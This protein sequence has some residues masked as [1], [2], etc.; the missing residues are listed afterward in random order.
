[1]AREN[2]KSQVLVVDDDRVL[3]ASF[4]KY[5]PRLNHNLAVGICDSSLQALT[6]VM[7]KDYDAIVVDIKMPEM[8]G[9]A[10]LRE[11]RKIRPDTPVFL[12]TGYY[13]SYDQAI[14]ALRGGATDFIHKP[15][16]WEHFISSLELAIQDYQ[17]KRQ[18]NRERVTLERRVQ[19]LEQLLHQK[20][21]SAGTDPLSAT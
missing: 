5:L 9:L 20:S 21:T 6:L 2:T 17:L 4:E 1:M 19:E 3:L 18:I 12:I 10:L 8:D 13:G 15:M 7:M 14:E 11:I 16:E